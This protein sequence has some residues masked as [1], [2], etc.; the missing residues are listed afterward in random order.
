MLAVRHHHATRCLCVCV[1][2]D[3]RSRVL[4]NAENTDLKYNIY[5]CSALGFKVGG[6]HPFPPPKNPSLLCRDD[7][8]PQRT[9]DGS[10]RE[11]RWSAPKPALSHWIQRET[12]SGWCAR[13]HWFGENTFPSISMPIYEWRG[14]SARLSRAFALHTLSTLLFSCPAERQLFPHSSMKT[15]SREILCNF[16]HDPLKSALPAATAQRARPSLPPSACAKVGVRFVY[17]TVYFTIIV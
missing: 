8:H 2:R 14:G 15:N 12:T 10:T 16:A 3:S 1:H 4:L 7:L 9:A 6:V 13:A 5:A 17:I 11:E